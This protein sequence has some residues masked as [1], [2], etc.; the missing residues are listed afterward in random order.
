LTKEVLEMN[1]Q[2]SKELQELQCNWEESTTQ[3]KD[4]KIKELVKYNGTLSKKLTQCKRNMTDLEKKVDDL[5]S[6]K[7]TLDDLFGMEM[8]MQEATST[9]KKASTMQQ[10][11]FDSV[12]AEKKQKQMAVDDIDE[13][14]VAGDSCF[15]CETCGKGVYIKVRF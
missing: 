3:K 10:A 5:N 7:E 8:V 4:A 1:C 15:G 11:C 12:P 9:P 13:A 14:E 2:V 6:S